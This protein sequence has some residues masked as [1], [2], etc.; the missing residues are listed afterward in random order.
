[1][2]LPDS[3]RH[4]RTPSADRQAAPGGDSHTP[5][6][7]DGD[8]SKAKEVKGFRVVRVFDVSQTEGEPLP[9][10]PAPMRLAGA[11]PAGVRDAL[12]AVAVSDG[13]TLQRDDC[14][15]AEGWTTT[16]TEPSS[17]PPTSTTRTPPSPWRTRSATFARN[18]EPASPAF[19]PTLAIAVESL[20][21]KPNPSPTWWPRPP[22]WVPRR[23]GA[24]RRHLGERGPRPP[25]CHRRT[26]H[27]HLPRR[28]LRR[29]HA[30]NRRR[31]RRTGRG[32]G[33]RAGERRPMDADHRHAF[34][35]PLGGHQ[36][37]SDRRLR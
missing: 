27:G 1:M 4:R 31:K 13:Y 32:S 11:A 8:G 30:A 14:G 10:Q 9:E 34:G 24:L 18:T 21:S 29:R 6:R 25:A 16:A 17:Y 28:P 12:V 7:P 37:P 5:I 35:A 2:H 20:K 15:T 36:A 23:V 33:S 19:A 3:P 22:G 26:S